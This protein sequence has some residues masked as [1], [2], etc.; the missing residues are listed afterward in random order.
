MG[1]GSDESCSCSMSTAVFD[2]ETGLM[3]VDV[4][5]VWHSFQYVLFL[6]LLNLISPVDLEV[7]MLN[8]LDLR[9]ACRL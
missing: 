2:N 3:A 7:E 9:P 8:R 6:F 5:G 4:C 1:T